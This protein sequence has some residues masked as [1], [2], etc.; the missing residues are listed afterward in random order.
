MWPCMCVHED[1]G[2]KGSEQQ[3]EREER[4]GAKYDVHLLSE[5]T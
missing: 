5:L 2:G 1:G 3:A 4:Q